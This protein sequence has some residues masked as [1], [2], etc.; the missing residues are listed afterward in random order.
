[1]AANGVNSVRTYTVPPR[2]LLDLAHEHG[3]WVMVGLPWEQH[4]AF[5]DDRGR[6]R[7]RS[8]S[9]SGEA[10]RTCAGHPAVLCYAIGNEIPASIV[11]WHGR[12]RIE[13]FLRRLYDAAKA[14][15]PE[16]LVT[17]VNY[18]ST[19]YLQLP[20]IDLVCFN[21]F[22]ESGPQFESYL[23]RLQNIAGDRP[24]LITETGLDSLRNSEERAGPRARLAGAHRVRRRLRRA[25]SCS[26]GPTSG[27]A[28]AT[29]SRTGTS[30]WSTATAQPKPALATVGKAF[31]ET[32]F[33]ADPDWPRD[34]GGRVRVQRRAHAAQLLRRRCS[35][36]DYPD[37]EVI[38]V[39][40]G[41]TDR[42]DEIT[43]GVRLPADQHREP[44]PG[45]R[46]QRGPARGDRRDRRLH[47]RRRAS[48]SAL[49]GAPR[50]RAS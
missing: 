28:A 11:R 1:M 2:W 29:T 4:I 44:G 3:L 40:D 30:A 39:N 48:R 23:A 45:E 12:H 38:V 32:P 13:R 7:R 49:A 47:R 10:V 20:F 26:P 5:L 34:L 25:C 18:P 27:T 33:R 50:D 6:A 22:L 14:E 42:T 15:D 19:E 8:S 46:A 37:Y 35:E 43:A 36:L 16:A 17:Y 9:A 24:L 41:S 21:V 31:A